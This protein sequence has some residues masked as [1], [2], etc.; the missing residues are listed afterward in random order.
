MFDDFS[1]IWNV[2]NCYIVEC[3]DMKL[4][5]SERLEQEEFS[6]PYI[7]ISTYTALHIRAVTIVLCK[8]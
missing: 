2:G 7:L 5:D 8:I 4:D 1:K 3:L 6:K